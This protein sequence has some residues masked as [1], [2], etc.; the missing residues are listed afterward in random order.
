MNRYDTHSN[1]TPLPRR[2]R[3]GPGLAKPYLA[4]WLV[5][6]AGAVT[7]L[8]VLGLAPGLLRSDAATISAASIDHARQ[9]VALLSKNVAALEDAV[10]KQEGGTQALGGQIGDLRDEIAGLRQQIVGMAG[11]NQE[12]LARLA[13]VEQT[14]MTGKKTTVKATATPAVAVTEPANADG[15]AAILGT[16]IEDE[17]VPLTKKAADKAK[18]AAKQ[19]TATATQAALAKTFGVELAQATSPE[20]LRMNWELLNEKHGPLFGGL[21][22]KAAGDPGNYRLLA[23]P[24]TSQAAA[25]AACVRLKA[26]NVSCNVTDFTGSAL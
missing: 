3:G 8:A 21:K 6:G 10:A 9:E 1:V 15:D 23:G 13:V 14:A 20:A 16:V 18:K 25:K 4:A 11:A 12:L 19:Q 2:D 22:A 17:P 7:Y 5:L 26:N 24:F